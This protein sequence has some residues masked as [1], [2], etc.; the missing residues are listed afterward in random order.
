MRGLRGVRPEKARVAGGTKLM[1]EAWSNTSRHE[2]Q[3]HGGKDET[4]QSDHE[5][6][7]RHLLRE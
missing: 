5:G 6:C 2:L 4:P 1:L 7:R 3:L